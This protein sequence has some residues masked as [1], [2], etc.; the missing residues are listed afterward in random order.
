MIVRRS[1]VCAAVLVALAGCSSTAAHKVSVDAVRQAAGKAEP[2]KCPITLDVPAALRSV[3][4]DL[5]A[6]LDST[7]AEVSKTST[8]AADLIAAARNGMSGLDA[9][10]GAYI[11]CNYLVGQDALGVELTA[12]RDLGAVDLLA[13]Q[14]FSAAS[15]RSNDLK[16]FLTSQPGLAQ[17]KLVGSS[18][19]V[20]RLPAGG[21]DA[22]MM[23]SSSVPSLHND[24]LRAVAGALIN[25]VRF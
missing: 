17:I 24:T 23:V 2:G 11:K 21:G 12:T 13:P 22:A 14:I 1:L 15:L 7:D 19:A 5:P 25:Q 20:G 9:T 4:V 6:Q 10:A 3:G 8:P 18:V 16:A